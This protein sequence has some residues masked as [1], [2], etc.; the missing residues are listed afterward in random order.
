MP[1]PIITSAD[2]TRALLD[3]MTNAPRDALQDAARCASVLPDGDVYVGLHSAL[4]TLRGGRGLDELTAPREV[5]HDDSGAPDIRNASA[6]LSAA[7]EQLGRLA[8]EHN[9]ARLGDIAATLSDIVE[10][11]AILP[12]ELAASLALAADFMATESSAADRGGQCAAY[13]VQAA[14]DARKQS[15]WLASGARADLVRRLLD[16]PDDDVPSAGEP[17]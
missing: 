14:R 1:L 16:S 2:L 7:V 5:E 11:A 3:A 9:D 12:R 15:D 13:L 6:W 10:R 17:A 4:R 8:V